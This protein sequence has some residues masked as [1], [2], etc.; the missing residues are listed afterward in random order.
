MATTT[1]QTSDAASERRRARD[2][3]GIRSSQAMKADRLPS[4]PR[5]R[6]PALAALAVLLI[7]GGAAVAA[8][9]AMR[10]DSRVPVLQA[11][12]TIYA[13]Q[14]LT[15]D[16]FTTTQVAAEDTALVPE[17]Q[18]H[19]VYGNYASTTINQGQLLDSYMV[20]GEGFLDDGR[21]AVGAALAVGRYPAEG[22]QPGDVVNLVRVTDDGAS[23][24]V[25]GASVSWVGGTATG[26]DAARQGGSAIL[27][28]TVMVDS[29][30]AAKVAAA[31]MNSQLA[32]VLVERGAGVGGGDG[33]TSGDNADDQS[34]DDADT[35]D[36][37]S[38]GDS[39]SEA[40][41]SGESGVGDQESSDEG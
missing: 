17:S 32:V 2:Q 26:E 23:T 29:D 25:S 40:R 12:Q 14:E 21:V 39:D 37:E 6:R 15:A 8:L 34:T 38:G 24:L 19:R 16:M 7:V 36:E 41:G 9:L 3:R 18:Q 20:S 30:D 31:N 33:V 11:N 10:V 13:G 5:Q 1:T 4:P 35:G 27:T 28:L 22:L